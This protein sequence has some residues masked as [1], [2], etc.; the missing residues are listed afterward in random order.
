MGEGCKERVRIREATGAN[1][2]VEEG[3]VGAYAGVTTED[4]RE[5]AEGGER[6][7]GHEGAGE[8]GEDDERCGLGEARAVAEARY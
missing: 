3:I 4:G 6:G 1:K 2:R 7:V 8:G 5:G